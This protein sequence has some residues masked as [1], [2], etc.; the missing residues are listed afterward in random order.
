MAKT[1]SPIL[2][3]VA[4]RSSD[5]TPTFAAAYVKVTTSQIDEGEHYELAKQLIVENGFEDCNQFFDDHEMPGFLRSAVE[6][7]EVGIAVLTNNLGETFI[8]DKSKTLFWRDPA[9]IKGSDYRVYQMRPNQH[10]SELEKSERT[11]HI[12]YGNGSEAEVPLS[13]LQ[14]DYD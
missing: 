5:G 1:K 11:A 4:C 8:K 14:Y 6:S 3:V 7:N 13:E 9:P 2:V 10:N 12:W